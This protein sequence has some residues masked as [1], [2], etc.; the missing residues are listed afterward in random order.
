MSPKLPSLTAKEIV[1]L[2]KGQGF[3]FISQK[4]SHAKYAHPDGRSTIIPMHAGETLG[5][6]LL[7]SLRA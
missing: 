1:K 7:L 5:P 6:G 2:V 3:E 4:G